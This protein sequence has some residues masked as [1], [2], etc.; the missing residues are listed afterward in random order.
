MVGWEEQRRMGVIPSSAGLRDHELD[1]KRNA[2]WSSLSRARTGSRGEVAAAAAAE[3][4]GKE[5]ERRRR[6][7]REGLA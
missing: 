1:W 3:N 5:K 6:I 7:E 2:A 4:L